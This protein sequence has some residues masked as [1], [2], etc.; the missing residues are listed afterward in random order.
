MK[1]NIGQKNNEDKHDLDYLYE[2]YRPTKGPVVD[3][4]VFYRRRLK[5]YKWLIQIAV[6]FMIFLLVFGLFKLNIPFT[7]SLKSG[8]RYLFTTETDVAP[9]FYKAVRVATQLGNLEWPVIE[10]VSPPAKTAASKAE[11]DSL[12][13]LPVSGRVILQYGWVEYPGEDVQVF[14]EG[15]DIA[16]SEGTEVKAAAGGTVTTGENARHGKYVMV[17]NA[18]GKMMRYAGLS[19]V[20]VENEQVVKEGDVLGKT[21]QPDDREPHLHFEVIVD[22]Q[23]ADPVQTLK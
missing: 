21:G 19:E 22:G 23:P 10:D 6:S 18:S 11:P 17:K 1:I 9:V 2:N 15:V 14:H 4:T 8:L 20:L 12:V 13:S 5:E 7:G 16:V 3:K